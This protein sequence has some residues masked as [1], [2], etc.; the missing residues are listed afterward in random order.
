M[1]SDTCYLLESLAIPINEE[2]LLPVS[3]TTL[4]GSFRGLL[5]VSV[6]NTISRISFFAKIVAT[7]KKKTGII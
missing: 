3:S 2:L 6:I 5:S 1:H 7:N 4:Y